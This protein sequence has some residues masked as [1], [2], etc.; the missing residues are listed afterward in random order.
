MK[1]NEIINLYQLAAD[2]TKLKGSYELASERVPKLAWE[3]YCPY[4]E[5]LKKREHLWIQDAEIAYEYAFMYSK[6]WP[7]AEPVIMK[8]PQWA[9]KYAR[10][11][12]RGR[13]PEAEPYI[14][15]SPEDA[16]LYAQ[17]VIGGRWPEAEPYI[18]KEPETAYW[19]VERTITER[20]PEAEPYLKKDPDIAFYY[21]MY[22]I[23]ERWPEAE[24]VIATDR[25]LAQQY[26]RQFGTNI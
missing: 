23:Q 2:T 18:M 15:K 7:E 10:N 5:E 25:N 24:P 12:I 17:Y 21:A 8:D 3:K 19:Y 22:I 14:M 13:W 1:L 6:R 26:N 11:V 4:P 20:C 9:C 16:N